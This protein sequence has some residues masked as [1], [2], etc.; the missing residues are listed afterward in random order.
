LG[1]GLKE[2]SNNTNTESIMSKHSWR[3]NTR[4]CRRLYP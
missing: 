4:T 1:R 2:E 3:L